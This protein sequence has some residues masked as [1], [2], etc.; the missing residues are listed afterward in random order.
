MKIGIIGGFILG[1]L[2]TCAMVSAWGLVLVGLGIACAACELHEEKLSE[3]Q[4]FHSQM[5]YPPY[6]Y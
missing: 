4:Q 5:N 2:L 3:K 6:G 1:G